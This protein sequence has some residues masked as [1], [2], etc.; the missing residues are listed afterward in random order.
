MNLT[1]ENIDP[2][3]LADKNSVRGALEILQGRL[4]LLE[5]KDKVIMSMYLEH[6]SRFR[7]IA[8]LTGVHEATIARRIKKL[9]RAILNGPYI[10]YRKSRHGCTENELSIIKDHFI[11]GL[12]IKELVVKYLV[13]EYRVRQLIAKVKG[14]CPGARKVSKAGVQQH[15]GV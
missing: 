2:R 5:G 7:Q 3:D 10:I 6:G 12:A 8:I 9:S 13:T 15:V 14:V 1:H 4:E 11:S